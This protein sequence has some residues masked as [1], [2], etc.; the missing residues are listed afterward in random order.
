M[1]KE[2]TME[3]QAHLF[4]KRPGAGKKCNSLSELKEQLIL[5]DISWRLL[6]EKLAFSE[7]FIQENARSNRQLSLCGRG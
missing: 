6:K 3:Q 4:T 5:G 2:I 1:E 7:E